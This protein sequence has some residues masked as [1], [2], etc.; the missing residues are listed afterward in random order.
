VIVEP[1]IDAGTV[2]GVTT[3]QPAELLAFDVV[4]QTNRTAGTATARRDTTDS[5]RGGNGVVAA[6]TATDGAFAIDN[7]GQLLDNAGWYSVRNDCRRTTDAAVAL[8]HHKT[9][10]TDDEGRFFGRGRERKERMDCTGAP[11]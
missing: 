2:K 7:D 10:C 8:Q 3:W 6:D 9:V 1:A 11:G 4:A 5:G